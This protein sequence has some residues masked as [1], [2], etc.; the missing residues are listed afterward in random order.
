MRTV[1]FVQIKEF[2]SL[3]SDW[4]RLEKGPDMTYFQTFHWYEML[5]NF[6]KDIHGKKYEIAFAVGKEDSEVKVIAPLWVIKR[7]FRR[8]NYKGVYIFGSEYWTDY[9]NFIYDT[10]DGEMVDSILSEI[11]R[12][13]GVDNFSFSKLKDTTQMSTHLNEKY[14]IE[15]SQSNVCVA[16]DIPETENEYLKLLTKKSRQNIRTAFNRMRKDGLSFTFDSSSSRDI[17]D[18]FKRYRNIRVKE[19]NKK[20]LKIDMNW[21]K[22]LI[23]ERMLFSF[24]KY[25]PFDDDSGSIFITTKNEDGE[26]CAA[27]NVGYDNYKK[28]IVVMAVSVNPKYNRYSPGILAMYT[29]VLK[30]M[31][32]KEVRRVDFTRGGESYKYDLGGKEHF[33]HS[34]K[35]HF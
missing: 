9:C 4:R 23:G 19:K 8:Y 5:A 25:T 3:E 30:N 7:T 13:Y 17:L 15:S 28:E 6:S 29:Y 32:T 24:P 31:E 18:E 21:L 26:L 11:K 34:L 2:Y 12:V 16:L 1:D 10:F 27:F 33:I 14:V 35:F 20:P 22:N